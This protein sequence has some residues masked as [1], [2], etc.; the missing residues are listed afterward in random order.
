MALIV[1]KI[2]AYIKNIPLTLFRFIEFLT[3]FHAHDGGLMMEYERTNELQENIARP[4]GSC[5]SV[6]PLGSGDASVH[7]V[8]VFSLLQSD[9]FHNSIYFFLQPHEPINIVVQADV[10]KSE[11][12]NESFTVICMEKKPSEVR[13]PVSSE[14]LV[15]TYSLWSLFL[16]IHSTLQIDRPRP[17]TANAHGDSAINGDLNMNCILN[18]DCIE[19][20]DPELCN[21]SA[22]E[23][24]S[25]TN[26]VG[27]RGHDRTRL[28]SV[29]LRCYYFC[30]CEYLWLVQRALLMMHLFRIGWK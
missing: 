20:T 26:L 24:N 27:Y 3:T 11:N 13:L 22:F 23:H 8:C 2:I 9:A 21:Y 12:V 16:F 5:E 28:D 4:R 25:R 15:L 7:Q 1:A 6:N 14:I 30:C 19:S 29:L 10:A 18:I 17:S